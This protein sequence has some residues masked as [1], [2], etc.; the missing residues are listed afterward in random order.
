DDLVSARTPVTPVGSI[1]QAGLALAE[2]AEHE[3]ACCMKSV[4]N[5][6]VACVLLKDEGVP[7]T[8]AVAGA[9]DVKPPRTSR[10]VQRSGGV[11]YH[12]E[13]TNQLNMVSGQR[14]D[15]W[16]CLIG[17]VPAERLMDLAD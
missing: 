11:T 5:K 16:V 10:A 17:A 9:Q 13:S 3:M 12:V 2:P 8:L 6:Q 15:R 4:R 1:Q 14:G 7:V